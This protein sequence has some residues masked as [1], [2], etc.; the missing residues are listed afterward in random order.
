VRDSVRLLSSATTECNL[1]DT[2]MS[3]RWGHQ[4]QRDEEN[5]EQHGDD[6]L[7]LIET[8]DTRRG[9]QYRKTRDVSSPNS[10]DS[11]RSG[12]VLSEGHS[13]RVQRFYYC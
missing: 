2:E 6:D 13:T 4:C 10:R 1:H 5:G 8:L 11:E 12:E 9:S 3:E 7:D